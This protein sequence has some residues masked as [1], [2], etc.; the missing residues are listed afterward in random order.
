MFNA[1]ARALAAAAFQPGGITFAG[2]HWCTDHQQCADADADA[3][4]NPLDVNATPGEPTGP[5]YQGRP[6]TDTHLP[7]V[8]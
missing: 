8:A 2:M 4:A 5:T 1:L 3:A 7:E 6:I